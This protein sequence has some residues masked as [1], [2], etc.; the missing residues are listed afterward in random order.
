MG[1]SSG[2][3]SEEGERLASEAHPD[4]L[5]NLLAQVRSVNPHY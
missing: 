1:A 5:M 4:D 3:S 2:S